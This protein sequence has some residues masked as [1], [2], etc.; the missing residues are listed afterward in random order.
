MD[1]Q[2]SAMFDN[3][4][5]DTFNSTVALQTSTNSPISQTVSIRMVASVGLIV[6]GLGSCANATVLAVLIR[7]RRQFGSN[8]HTLIANQCAMDLFACVFGMVSLVVML[9]M[10]GYRYNGDEILDGTFCVVLEGAVLSAVGL[11]AEIIGLIVITLERYF[12]IVH[13]I[14]HR[15][16]YRDWMT[17]VGV[18]LPWIGG[19]CL[20]LFPAM[21][22]TRV[23]N[24]QCMRMAV[25]PNK[26]MARVSLHIII[27]CRIQS[28]VTIFLCY[29]FLCIR[30]TSYVSMFFFLQAKIARCVHVTYISP[31]IMCLLKIIF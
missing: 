6:I 2:F 18:A 5:E 22:T 21:G 29:S 11:T 7:A 19:T 25:W 1:K 12:K 8:V 28:C 23:V 17:K 30:S 3:S 15:K 9:T 4:S 26:Y 31:Y 20:I 16:Y 10:R 14:A 27:F 13:A 24:G